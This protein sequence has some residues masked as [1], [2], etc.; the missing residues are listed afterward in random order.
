MHQHQSVPF[1]IFRDQADAVLHGLPRITDGDLLPLHL[2]L[3]LGDF[4]VLAK[5]CHYQFGAPG[6]HQSGN[7]EDFTTAKI[8]GNS[9]KNLVGSILG[10]QRMQVFNLENDFTGFA[11]AFGESFLHF[12]PHHVVH[13]GFN[14]QFFGRLGDYHFAVA[15]HGDRICDLEKLI[16]FVADVNTG[17]AM[18]LESPQDLHELFNLGLGQRAGRFIQDQDL[19]ILR[20]RLGDFRHLHLAY[21]QVFDDRMRGDIQMIFIQ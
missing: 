5:Q 2:D 18:L 3:S 1:A 4:G 6:S 8:E 20:K 21:T 11:I 17:D 14:I 13:Q 12:A 19:G 15:K 7:S 10:I 9:F 16:Q